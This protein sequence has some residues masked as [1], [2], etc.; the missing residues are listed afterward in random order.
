MS[1]NNEKPSERWL[2]SFQKVF[3]LGAVFEFTGGAAALSE[4]S[5][6]YRQQPVKP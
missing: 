5:Q 3:C 2:N 6:N 4:D 1:L